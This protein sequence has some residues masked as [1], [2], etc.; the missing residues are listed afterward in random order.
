VI[1]SRPQVRGLTHTAGASVLGQTTTTT[2]AAPAASART[3][4]GAD[5]RGSM[6]MERSMRAMRRLHHV[7]QTSR[8][9]D[10]E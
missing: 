8:N 4:S 7:V 2:I 3:S 5:S 1:S 9:V 10:V 6:A